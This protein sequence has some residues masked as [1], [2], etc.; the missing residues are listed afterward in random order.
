MCEFKYTKR[1]LWNNS[2]MLKRAY[3]LNLLNSINKLIFGYEVNW[4]ILVT[5][6]KEIKRD[7]YS[8]VNEKKICLKVKWNVN[9]FENQGNLPLRLN[10]TYKR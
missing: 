7:F 4:N 3:L 2:Y 9:L 1:L 8:S 10:I 6:G 5:S